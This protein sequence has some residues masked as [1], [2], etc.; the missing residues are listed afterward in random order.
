M[1]MKTTIGAL[2]GATALSF[3]AGTAQ[4]AGEVEVEPVAEPPCRDVDLCGAG[5]LAA[6]E[7]PRQAGQHKLPAPLGAGNVGQVELH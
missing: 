1:K 4:A 7:I 6:V 5:D 2:I 3:A